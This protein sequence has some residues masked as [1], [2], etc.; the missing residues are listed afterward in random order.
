VQGYDPTARNLDGRLVGEEVLG[1]SGG[2][3]PKLGERGVRVSLQTYSKLGR[4][5]ENVD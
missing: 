2:W 1:A 4:G 5:L 3:L